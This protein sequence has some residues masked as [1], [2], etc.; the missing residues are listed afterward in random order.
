MLMVFLCLLLSVLSTI[1]DHEDAATL[2][3]YYIVRLVSF[4]IILRLL[5]AHFIVHGFLSAY[6]V[7]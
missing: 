3:L 4:Y 7:I 2:A 1:P 6:P 5:F